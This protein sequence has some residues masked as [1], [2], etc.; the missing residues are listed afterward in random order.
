MQLK[1]RDRP[2]KRGWRVIK[3]ISILLAGILTL[4]SIPA[5][6]NVFEYNSTEKVSNIVSTDNNPKREGFIVMPEN[7]TVLYLDPSPINGRMYTADGSSGGDYS[8]TDDHLVFHNLY[9]RCGFLLGMFE[10]NEPGHELKDYTHMKIEFDLFNYLQGESLYGELYLVGR[11]AYSSGDRVNG[12]RIMIDKIEDSSQIKLTTRTGKEFIGENFKVEYLI[13][14]N[15]NVPWDSRIQVFLNGEM[16][17]SLSTLVNTF[18][19][20]RTITEI[21]FYLTGGNYDSL[22][23]SNLV[24]TACK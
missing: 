12:T 9:S 15:K 6:S 4:L 21:R 3:V 2:G 24:V 18:V 17:E 7:R 8:K 10:R 13:E 1:Q 14:V 22:G 20:I 23:I 11:D 16:V 5:I 19:L